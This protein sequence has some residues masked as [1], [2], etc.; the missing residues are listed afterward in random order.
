MSETLEMDFKVS[1]MGTLVD[2][3]WFREHARLGRVAEGEMPF[4]VT[5][6]VLDKEPKPEMVSLSAVKAASQTTTR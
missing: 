3:Q 2:G 1:A 6:G 4:L 5:G